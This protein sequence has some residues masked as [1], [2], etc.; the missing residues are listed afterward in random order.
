M[1]A[2]EF[3]RDSAYGIGVKVPYYL[4]LDDH[5]D[6]TITPFLLSGE[7]AVLETEYR[8][9]FENGELELDL[10]FGVTNYNDDGRGAE[11]RLGGFGFGS[12]EIDPGVI[13]GFDLAF[14]ADDAFLRRYD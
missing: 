1:L 6:M 8:R 14:T 5:S 7:G 3:S 2:P 9:Q 13:A 4:V 11:A 10:A 12:Y